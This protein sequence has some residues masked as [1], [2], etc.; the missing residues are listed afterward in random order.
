MSLQPR[1]G[2]QQEARSPRHRPE[3]AR[4]SLDL[5]RDPRDDVIRG[6]FAV[7]LDLAGGS[8]SLKALTIF[9]GYS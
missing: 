9:V 6:R 8:V 2:P 3:D 7:A 4:S 1:Q 5:V